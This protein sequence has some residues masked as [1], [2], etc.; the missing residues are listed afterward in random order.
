MNRFKI[1]ILLLALSFTGYGQFRMGLSYSKPKKVSTFVLP[2]AARI[3]VT[4]DQI[5][6]N[7]TYYPYSTKEMVDG[8][9]TTYAAAISGSPII[10]IDLGAKHKL[11]KIRLF[12]TF[13][14]QTIK[15]AGRNTLNNAEVEQ[16]IYSGSIGNFNSWAQYNTTI[17][18]RYIFFTM[19]SSF[20]TFPTEFQFYG[21][22]YTSLDLVT[23]VT[24]NTDTISRKW[25]GTNS[26][27]YTVSKTPTS[28]NW[29][30]NYSDLYQIAQ[31]KDSN[32]FVHAGGTFG[33]D[34]M[35]TI[36]KRGFTQM[37]CLQEGPN[38]LRNVSANKS[39]RNYWPCPYNLSNIDPLS[40][41]EYARIGKQFAFRYG[42]FTTADSNLKLFNKPGDYFDQPRVSGLNTV[43]YIEFWNE[44]N[45]WWQGDSARFTPFQLA[46]MYSAL[47][48][49]HE[50]RI[51]R[52]GVKI[53]DPT[54][55]VVLSGLADDSWKYIRL[56]Y[57]WFK[58]NRTDG[59]FCADMLN[60]H[61]Y[62]N[63][64]AGQMSGTKGVSPERFDFSKRC[65]E[66]TSH[67]KAF[68]P[69]VPVLIT[70]FGYDCNKSV[71]APNDYK[72]YLKN[73]V[74]AAW[75]V[76]SYLNF[77]SSGMDGAIVFNIE[78][79]ADQDTNSTGNAALY[80]M[81]GLIDKF[82]QKKP[83]AK[84]LTNFSTILSN[85]QWHVTPDTANH[86]YTIT[87]SSDTY[88]FYWNKS[89]VVN[90]ES[91]KTKSAINLNSSTFAETSIT[92]NTNYNITSE[93]PFVI[94]THIP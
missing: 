75:L 69:N 74:Q 13:G 33:D 80:S 7:L 35:D 10:V 67:T 41:T 32:I 78:D 3:S 45:K 19:V 87:N 12:H 77:A 68:L 36:K 4:D 82:N 16:V 48:D 92:S 30:R 9:S 24:L 71:Q 46:A 23:P 53:A 6:N 76:R 79:N 27:N 49:G 29:F 26:Y 72:G 58:D 61:N 88:D 34:K 47:Y 31:K 62:A 52:A 8:D 54:M 17:D 85:K 59:K 20:A 93:I 22:P 84:C 55:Q 42:A 94:H 81:S 38:W 51:S 57:L 83:S 44:P 86:R 65:K 43:K 91:G 2:A 18:C 1:I 25:L 39:K 14:S 73:D 40:Y 5:L 89:I 63:N 90:T 11:Q 50:G 56:M 66:F 37:L 21:S 15:L 70:E 60:F 28:L 64:G